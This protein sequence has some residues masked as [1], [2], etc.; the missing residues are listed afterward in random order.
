MNMIDKRTV[1]DNDDNVFTGRTN[2]DLPKVIDDLL[3]QYAEADEADLNRL[4]R[5]YPQ[6][7]DSIGW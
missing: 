4:M 7:G 6:A 3:W 5:K 2:G 1:R